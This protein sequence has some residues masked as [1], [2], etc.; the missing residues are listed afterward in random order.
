M[1][2]FRTRVFGLSRA[3]SIAVIALMLASFSALAPAMAADPKGFA[4]LVEA[5]QAALEKVHTS[6]SGVRKHVPSDQKVDYP[7]TPPTSGPH[8]DTWIKAGVYDAPQTPERLVHSLEH[9]NIVIYYGKLAPDAKAMLKAWTE[10]YS[11]QWD[12]VVVAPLADLDK[13]VILTAWQKKLSLDAFD[14]AAAAAFVDAFRG[15]GPERAVR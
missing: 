15:R 13:G 9:G 3:A 11:G 14:P 5:G 12:A 6:A 10:A 2:C 8:Y 4:G 7:E 1:P